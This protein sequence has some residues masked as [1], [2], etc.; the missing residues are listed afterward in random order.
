[1][2]LP[3]SH[4]PAAPRHIPSAEATSRRG[5]Q[6]LYRREARC[7]HDPVE[8]GDRALRAPHRAARDRRPRDRRSSRPPGC[9]S[10]EPADSAARCCSILRPPASGR[11]ESSTT[12]TSRA[13]TCSARCC[14][15]QADLGADKVA[16]AAAR[17][18]DL[19]PHVAVEPHAERITA[20][21]AERLAAAY[22]AVVDGSD[23]WGTRYAVSDACLPGQT[24]AGHGF[25]RH[26][27]RGRDGAPAARDGPRTGVRTRPI[28]VCFP[29]RR[30]R[31]ACRPVRRPACSAR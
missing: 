13:R 14:S 19:N 21:N 17:L 20:A 16:A 30:P 26:F 10:W 25:G 9:W 12:T 11:S 4:A 24:A 22:D 29:H 2:R 1:M 8:R 27:R 18:T 5:A 6:G 28:D 7:A 3:I 31:A 23:N 15:A